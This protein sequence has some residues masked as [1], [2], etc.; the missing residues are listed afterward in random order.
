MTKNVIKNIQHLYTKESV[1]DGI[2]C[3]FDMIQ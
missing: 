2:T 1:G 3:F